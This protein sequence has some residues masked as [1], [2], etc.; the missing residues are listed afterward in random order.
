[1]KDKIVNEIKK[2]KLVFSTSPED[3]ISAY[4]REIET[5]KEYNGRQL[6][7]LLQ[8]ADDEDSQKVE[9]NL[10]T[11]E[12]TLS[13][14][15]YGI[16]AKAFSI[17]G[18]KSLMISNL[19]P[20]ITKKYIG[21]KGLGFRSIINW[22]KEIS[23][24]S[25]NI[26]IKFSKD[27]AEKQYNSIFTN[28]QHNDIIK[29][30][31]Y[32]SHIKPIPML[33]MPS[34][35]DVLSNNW[36]TIINIKYMK[37]LEDDIKM[38]ITEIR[39]EILLFLNNLEE[40]EIIIDNKILKNIKKEGLLNKWKIYTKEGNID[41][42]LWENKDIPEQYKLMLA[43][44]DELD[45]DIKELFSFF[46]TKIDINLPFI[47]H[48][49]FELNSSRNE[50]NDSRKNRFILNKLVELISDTAK[51]LTTKKVSYQAL[52]MLTYSHKNYIL[53]KLGFYDNII[54]Y[55][56]T[57]KIFPCIDQIYR[58]K[59][60][61]IYSDN[62]SNFIFKTEN[63][64]LF[65]NL[66]IPHNNTIDLSNFKL[67]T[68]IDNKKINLL[69]Q[70]IKDI[71]QRV[72]LIDLILKSFNSFDEKLLFLID[73]NKDLVSVDD[74]VYTPTNKKI[75]I[76]K[77]LKLKFINK[78]L[79]EKL[80]IKLNITANDKARELQRILKSFTNIQSY[81]A[82]PI[83]Q[84]IVSSTNNQLDIKGINKHDVIKQ[85]VHSLYSNYINLNIT[86]EFPSPKIQLFSQS[87]DLKQ[88][89]K[90]YLSKTYI[91]GKLTE[92]LFSNIIGKENFLIDLS[93]YEFENSDKESI[94][95]FFLWL[96]VNKYT[97]TIKLTTSNHYEYESYL[98]YVKD[99]I[100]VPQGLRN[101]SIE[102]LKI[103]NFDYIIKKITPEKLILWLLLDKKVKD[104]LSDFDNK[105]ILKYS[106][107]GESTYTFKHSIPK[108]PSYIIYQIIQSSFF[109]DYLLNNS[110]ISILT[111]SFR[112]NYQ[113]KMFLIYN[114]EKE[115]IDWILPKIGA[116]NK[117]ENLSIEIVKK[118]LS[119]LHTK[120]PN[121]KGAQTFYKLCIKHF[122]KNHIPLKDS[123]IK[124]FAT[125]KGTKDYYSVSDVY[126]SSK[127][128]LPKKITESIALFHYPKRLGEKSVFNFFG[129][130]SLDDLEIDI[131]SYNI[132]EKS[133]NEFLKIFEN[134]KPFILALRIKDIDDDRT[135][136][137]IILKLK[138]TKILLCDKVNY[139]VQGKESILDDNDYLK[140]DNHFLIKTD[141]SLTINDLIHN[142][143]FQEAF[144]DIIGLTFDIQETKIFR[145]FI[146]EDILYTE[147]SMVNDFGFELI[148][149]S[150][151]L[152]DTND[153]VYSFWKVIYQL[154]GIKFTYKNSKELLKNI[155][156]DLDLNIDINKI[157]YSKLESYDSCFSI[158]LLFTKLKICPKEFN[159]NHSFYQID[160]LQY[161]K[162]N[163]K[164]YFESF[165]IKFKRKVY[166][167]C[168][169]EKKEIQF[170]NIFTKYET[171]DEYILDV[172]RQNKLNMNIDLD[173]IASKFIHDNFSFLIEYNM[174]N[175]NFDEIFDENSSI[176][177]VE[178]FN[179]DL[180]LYSLMYF[181][182]SKHRINHI[183]NKKS[184]VGNQFPDFKN[185]GE[186]TKN[187]MSNDYQIDSPNDVILVNANLRKT[188]R[189]SNKLGNTP[190]K[191][192]IQ[193]DKKKKE[194]G[195]N[196]E[197]IVFNKLLSE[198]GK[199]NV[200]WSSKD[201]DALGFDI[202]YKNKN[203]EWKYVE[204][205]TYNGYQ[206]YLT[207]NEKEYAD[208]H[209][210]E[211]EIFLVEN[212]KIHIINNIDFSTNKMLK[213]SCSQFIVQYSL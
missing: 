57:A 178:K 98:K 206:F 13:I 80:I 171:N 197:K 1:M 62:L 161:N 105:D 55:M 174:T 40:L 50:I 33:S 53:E 107:M 116:T 133:T 213:L 176:I 84:K 190:F 200:I 42:T 7:E 188:E 140:D 18:I 159:A 22:S 72:N 32:P 104:Q 139:K 106:K 147:K 199:D 163:I 15:N 113:D 192:S 49:T 89:N 127:M 88:S 24:I 41:S 119:T 12:N 97:K 115:D 132:N 91:S 63:S 158:Q 149:R 6:L 165:F 93:F 187:E 4:T 39:D 86:S 136:N 141:N 177:N 150:R 73:E 61:V 204:V 117:F 74:E 167:Y 151:E 142:F 179:G 30:T 82:I 125:K 153:A 17:D 3:M 70:N 126:Y 103:V 60:E 102:I 31:K 43:L 65:N 54:K 168:L 92:Y 118:T 71:N 100:E 111:N 212:K 201:N 134:V 83:I 207:R 27:I 109:K 94:E 211:Y 135:I 170:I 209:I 10:N 183:I 23:I 37:Y 79:Y 28:I 29:K 36:T 8:N 181:K 120:I 195:D 121:G 95:E 26:E 210:G 148:S 173:N 180:D 68:S 185:Q 5:Q 108:K 87:M 64:Y 122:E 146:K 56:E 154:L 152:L 75:T 155:T 175:I 35:V 138:N 59:D 184:K 110:N 52:V 78:E 143:D 202:K 160:F 208:N 196:A 203:N 156:S 9:I 145:D 131:L 191:Y 85:M 99:K 169:K 112:I 128:K 186:N 164:Q 81:D 193:N 14:S 48:G 162:I 76:P 66:L 69:S 51:N 67:S 2:R 38:Q 144:A 129:I 45:N 34:V 124:L 130:N 114:I 77:Y 166:T 194:I 137:G 157:D 19:S 11:H 21:N 189:S 25:E 172:S 47:V 58:T 44:N 198:Y 96:G 20:K 90:L 182:N 205:K 16:T 46:P 123:T 101:W